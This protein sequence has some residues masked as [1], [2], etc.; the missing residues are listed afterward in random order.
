MKTGTS[1]VLVEGFFGEINPEVITNF[2]LEYPV[3]ALEVE[4]KSIN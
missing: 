1:E 3:V 4:F 2:E